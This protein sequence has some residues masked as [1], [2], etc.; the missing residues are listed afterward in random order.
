MKA[1][2]L[3]PAILPVSVMDNQSAFRDDQ[4][5]GQGH[6]IPYA[7]APQAWHSGIEQEPEP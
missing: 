6:A 3:M 2:L 1:Q 7:K 4:S 5:V